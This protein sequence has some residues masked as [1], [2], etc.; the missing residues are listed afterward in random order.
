MKVTMEEPA[1]N[2]AFFNSRL[3]GAMFVYDK[4]IFSVQLVFM[5][6]AR[7]LR[8]NPMNWVKWVMVL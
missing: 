5:W 7:L 2:E 1:S 4:M 3:M 6:R 8:R